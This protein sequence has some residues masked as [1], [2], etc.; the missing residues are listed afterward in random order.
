MIADNENNKENNKTKHSNQENCCEKAP[1]NNGLVLALGF[2]DGVHYGHQALL[3]KTIAVAKENG[4]H[5]GVMTFKTH[6]LNLIF[7]AY[8]PK[9]ITTNAEKKRLI[10]SFGIEQVFFDDFNE[11]LMNLSAEDFI[12]DYLLMKYDVRHLV[13]GFNYTFG[14]KGAGTT[15]D[16]R[17]L[18]KLYGFG[19]SVIPPTIIDGGAVSSTRIRELISIGKVDKIE[20][21]LGRPYSIAGK[22]VKGKQLGRQYDVPTANLHLAE[23]VIMPDTGVYFTRVQ[24]DGKT[25][26]GLT[27]LGYNPTFDKHPYSI[28]TY[29]YDFDGDLYD[30]TM[31]LTFLH[32][33]RGEKKF[34]SVDALFK[35]IKSDIKTA[36]KKYRKHS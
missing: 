8:A 30:K 22:I 20:K 26:D 9:I 23:P 31:Q 33:I 5:S 17:A 7:P 35:R 27:N 12:R 3:K 28:E 6:P 34:K 32:K 11:S 14:Y 29:V 24:V 2:F 1:D 13:V 10:L 25:L 4:W 18:G 21:L 19:V 16:L 36:D 15:A